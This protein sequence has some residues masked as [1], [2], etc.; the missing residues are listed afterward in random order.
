MASAWMDFLADYRKKHPKLKGAE[1]MK[2]AGEE[3]RKKGGKKDAKKEVA[4]KGGKKEM[5]GMSEK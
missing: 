3:Y 2:K 4:K 1:V 5:G